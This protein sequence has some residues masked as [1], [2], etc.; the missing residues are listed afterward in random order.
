[1]RAVNLLPREEVAK[2][3]EKHRGVAFGAAGGIALVTAGIA[4]LVLGAGGSI[5]ERQLQL[6][7]LNAQLAAVPRPVANP[8]AT[9][10]AALGAEKS[11]RTGALSTAL[12]G[13][14]AWDR[15]L[16]DISQVLPD[17]V[18]LVS[19]ASDGAPTDPAAAAAGSNVTL[20]GSTYSQNGV[21]RFL[22][23]LA[24]VPALS[25]VTLQT[26]TSTTIGEQRL[27]QFE[28][29]AQVKPPGAGA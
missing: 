1:V 23:R 22:S 20:V 24:V 2:S 27:V 6:D 3:F 25:S 15:V 8:A 12:A 7:S 26:S 5:K 17:D 14:V 11:A 28:I 18:W 4:A 29:R 9:E 21:A 16:R 19:L 13:R 10:A